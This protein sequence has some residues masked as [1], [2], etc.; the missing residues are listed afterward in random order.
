MEDVVRLELTGPML[1]KFR[2]I[3]EY[4]GTK[5]NTDLIRL[6]IADKYEKLEQAKTK[7]VSIP[8]DIYN[9]MAEIARKHN[10]DVDQYMQKITVKML[11]EA[12]ANSER[13]S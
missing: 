3:K 12:Y 1:D 10:L 5:R 9:N 11:E 2:A 8:I 13:F 4:Y 7:K 6:L